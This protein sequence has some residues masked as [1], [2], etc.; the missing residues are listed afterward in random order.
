MHE[1]F[2]CDYNW[3]GIEFPA[4]IKNWKR[5]E[6]IIKQLFLKFFLYHIMKKQ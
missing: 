3:E 5:F 6:K 4:G 1:F 2:S